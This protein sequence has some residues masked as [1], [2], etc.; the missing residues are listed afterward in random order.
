M[1]NKYKKTT[2]MTFYL[3]KDWKFACRNEHWNGLQFLSFCEVVKGKLSEIRQN[4]NIG[5]GWLIM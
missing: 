5:Y 2:K 1:V 3:E 4:C